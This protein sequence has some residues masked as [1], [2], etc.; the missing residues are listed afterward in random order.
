MEIDMPQFHCSPQ[1]KLGG[2]I[3]I[4]VRGHEAA[5]TEGYL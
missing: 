5:R 1:A 3:S 4:V 2:D